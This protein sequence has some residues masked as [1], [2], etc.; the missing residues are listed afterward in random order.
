FRTTLVDYRRYFFRNPLTFAVRLLYLGRHGG[1]ADDPRL[2]LLDIGSNHTVRGYDIDSIDLSECTVVD[3]SSACPELDR[4]IGT[5]IGVASFELRLAL[6]GTQDLGLFEA[7][8][9][10][11]ELAFFIDA[12]AAWSPGQS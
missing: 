8:A 12:G 5:R 4:L 1:D 3:G 11:T 9:A 10:P 2:P 7:P 6:L